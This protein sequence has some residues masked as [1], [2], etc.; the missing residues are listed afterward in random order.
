MKYE[1]I[2]RQFTYNADTGE[3]I[4]RST[5]EVT[6]TLG[7]RG[8]L[9][10]G[11]GLKTIYVHRAIWCLHAGKDLSPK[12]QIDHIN[13][14]RTDNRPVNMRE[15][16]NTGNSK[17]KTMRHINTSGATGVS[18]HKAAGKWRAFIKVDYKQVH[19]G[20]YEDFNEA[21]SARKKAEKI[22]DFHENHQ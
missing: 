7:G 20:L 12:T 14:N 8:Y 17:N 4:R 11:L 2:A 22:Y 13:H 15:T 1:E 5:G 10:C 9:V 18:W 16:D 3:L 6:G 21:V 19:L